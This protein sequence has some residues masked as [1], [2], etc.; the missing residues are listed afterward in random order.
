MKEYRMEWEEYTTRLVR[1]LEE[2]LLEAGD[3]GNLTS[4]VGDRT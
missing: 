3:I 2:S 4:D 1:I